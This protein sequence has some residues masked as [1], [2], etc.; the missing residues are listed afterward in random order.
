CGRS[1]G[2]VLGGGGARGFAHLGVLDELEAAGVQVD[3]VAGTSMG[4]V[5]GALYA[6]GADAAATDAQAYESFVRNNPLGDYT[7]PSKSLL[8]GRRTDSLLRDAMGGMLIE[9]SPRE[10]RCVSVDLLQRRRVVHRSGPL[11]DAMACSLRLPGIYPPYEYGGALHVD[12]GVLDNLPV[13]TLAR[14][15]G[16]ILA[17]AI[18]FAGRGAAAT[19]L[20]VP[21]LG[22]TL[23]RTMT[24]G[25]GDAAEEA[26]AMADLVLRPDATGVGLTEWHQID[27]MRESGRETTRAAI[28]QIAAVLAR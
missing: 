26:M 10:F 24:M 5:I 13:S 19:S 1:V 11:A 8:R 22:D 16:P 17:V 9:E 25:S 28:E 18:G 21:S 12:G 6:S 2:L 15:E 7:L 3:R 20:K 4:A 14:S 23:I 27:R